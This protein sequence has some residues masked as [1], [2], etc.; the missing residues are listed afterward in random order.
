M[1]TTSGELT[2]SPLGDDVGFNWV[3][4]V[5][6]LFFLFYFNRL[7]AT[8][9]SYG[10][11]AWTWHKY[12][13]YID[14][15]A[16]Q[17]SLLG[18]R[19]FFKGLRYH[20]NNETILIH[21]GFITWCYWLR[22][23]R[24]LHVDKAKVSGPKRM[25]SDSENEGNKYHSSTVGVEDV[26]IQNPYKLPCRINISLH[27][28]EWFVY[29]RSAA[30][31]AVIASMTE[32]KEPVDASSDQQYKFEVFESGLRKRTKVTD[33]EKVDPISKSSNSSEND[34]SPLTESLGLGLSKGDPKSHESSST[35]QTRLNKVRSDDHTSPGGA[36]IL[37]FLPIQVTCIKA[38][39]VL[40][41]ENTKSVL[42]AKAD[43][44][45]GEIDA[46]SSKTLDQYRQ[47]INFEFDHPVVQ[48]KPNDDYKEDQTATATRIKRGETDHPDPEKTH[49]HNHTFL[50]RQ[51][52]KVWHALQD[53]VPA[54]RS[55]VDS[56]S[57]SD[58]PPNNSPQTG[59]GFTGWQGL[60]RYLDEN[61]QD[62]KARWSAIEYATV[63]TIADSPK[64]T[65][66]F[67][68]D[69]VGT[70][71][72]K[73]GHQ[74]MGN[75]GRIR[76]INGD[77][78]PEWG[79]D[80]LLNGA[81]I[82]YGPWADRQRADI[83]RAFFPS[84]CKDT[85]P[86][87]NLVPGQFRVPT[88]FKV[89][90]EFDKE[91]TVRIPIRE[92]SKNWRWAKH[93]D[94]IGARQDNQKGRSSKHRRR[95]ADKGNPGPEIRPFGW[96][97]VKVGANATASY[98]M[99]MVAGPSG[100]SNTLELDL[101]NTEI[102]TSVNHG[103]LWRSVDNKISCDLSNP[104]KW[105][106]H[107]TWEFDVASNGLELFLLREHIF[108]L[109]DLV[110]D[111]ASGPPPDYLTYSPFRY[112]VNLHLDNFRLYLNVNDSN[113]INNPS[114]FDDNTFIII[115][116]SVLN[117]K[118]CI[119]LDTYRPFRN[120][121]SFDVDG[122]HGGLN[123]H[124][125]PWNTQATFLRS[126]ELA[127]LKTLAINGKY[128]F[129]ADT[130][131]SNTDTLLL[132]L[133]G[134]AP[135]A[136]FYG[137]VI[138]Y[139]LK[140]KDNYFGDDIRFKTLEE[141]QQVLRAQ[142]EDDNEARDVQP[143]KKSNDLDVI[144][145]ITVDDSSVILPSNLY[146]AKEHIRIEIATIA[147]D[148]RFTNY[149]M[150]LDVI[151]S[152]LA[153][154]L[155][156][157][158]SGSTTPLSATSST[159][160]FIDGVNASGNRLFGLPPTEPTY[161]CNWDFGV[162]AVTGEC[163]MDF[164]GRLAGG[165]RAFAFSFE[166]DENALPSISEVIL[167]DI[168]FLR[169]SLQSIRIWLH[170][171][172][173][174]FLFSTANISVSFND[175][176]GSHYSQK[177]NI[178][179]P[180]VHLGCVDAESAS[181]HRSRTQ[182]PVETHAFVQTALSIAMVQ[183]KLGFEKDRQLQQ[184]H[185]KRHDQRTH[186][187][188]FLLHPNLL[189]DSM[190]VGV[191]PPAMCI[192]PIALP[193]SSDVDAPPACQ[194]IHSEKS[195]LYQDRFTGRKS[196]FL[197]ISSTSQ[198]SDISILRPNSSRKRGDSRP[199]DSRSR[200]LQAGA[201]PGR[202][203]P[204]RDISAS[205]GRRSSFYSAVGDHR[206][207]PPSTVTFSS[208][209]MAPYFPLEGVEPDKKDLPPTWEDSEECHSFKEARF[210]LDDVQPDRVN[211]NAAHVSFM[212]ELPSGLC[213]VF[214][215]KAVSA[216]AG[217]VAALQASDP[218]DILDEL[219]IDSMSDIFDLKKHR[220]MTRKVTDLSVRAPSIRL[221]FLNAFT[222]DRS[223]TSAEMHDQYDMSIS[224]LAVTTRS[225][226][227]ATSENNLASQIQATSSTFHLSLASIDVSAKERYTDIQDPQVAINGVLE[228]V[229]CWVVSGEAT[230]AT[231]AF[232]GIEVA[233]ASSKIEYLAS[234]LH[235]TGLL[236]SD[237]SGTFSNLTAQQ[238]N[239]LQ[240]FTYL[241]A[242]AGQQATDPLFLTRPSYVLRSAT[243]HLRTTDSWKIITRLRHMYDSLHD[244]TKQDISMRCSNNSET[245]PENA[246]EN[247]LSGFDNWRSWDLND[248]NTCLV[249]KRVYGP[250]LENNMPKTETSWP[251]KMTFRTELV[252]LV[253]DPG[254]K[255]NEI[256]LAEIVAT[257]E[258]KTVNVKA[259]SQSP[260]DADISEMTVVQLFCAD[261][262]INLNWELCELAD[263]IMKLYNQGNGESSNDNRRNQSPVRSGQSTPMR[264]KHD[265]HI[266]VATD[267]GSITLDTINIRATSLSKGLNASFVVTDIRTGEKRKAATLMLAAEAA[268][269]KITSHSQELT[270][271]QIHFPS[272]FISH[273][274]QLDNGIPINTIKVA[275][276]C[277]K[278]SFAVRQDI[279]ALVEVLDLIIGD[280]AAQ[281]Y[282]LKKNM[283]AI[284]SQTRFV[285]V[286]RKP[287]SVTKINVALVL[288]KYDISILL[289]QSL[290]YNISGI[291]ARASLAAEMGSEVV[292]DFDVKENSHDMQTIFANSSRSISLLQVPPTNG[293]ITCHILENET[294]VSVFASVEPVELDAA[295][296]HSLLTA[297]N[298]PE[299]SSVIADVKE[300]V[301]IMETHLEEIFGTSQKPTSKE[302]KMFI[303]DA[304]L[305][306]A[307]FNIFANAHGHRGDSNRAR[308]DFNLGCVQL[309]LANRLDQDGPVLAFPEMRVSLQEIMFELSRWNK[310]GMEPCGN[311]AFAAF[312]T[313]TS[314]LSDT[315]NE[316]R[317]FHLKSNALKINLF[318]DTASSVLDVIGYLQEKIKDLDL[319]REKDYLRRLRQSKPRIAI[320]EDDQDAGASIT[321]STIMFSSMY[322]LE[323]LNVQV[324]WLVG[325]YTRE[326]S[327]QQ[328]REDLV[329]SLKRIDLSTKKENSARLTIE[330]L[331]L[332]MVPASQDKTQRTLNSALL[333]EVIFNVGYVSTQDTRRLAFQ[334][335]GKSLDLR[336]TSQFII[337]ASALR[338]S[339]ESAAEKVRAV[340]A[341]W[342][343]PAPGPPTEANRRQ[344][345]F[346][347]K[348][349]ESLLIDADFAG[350][351]VYLS[352]K[353]TPESTHAVSATTSGRTPQ[354]GRYGQF[355]QTD[356]S[357]NT[358]LRAPGLAWRVEFKDNGLDEPS[359][360]AELKVD[361]S[362]NI[363]Y[364]TVVPLIMEISSTVKEIVS[365]DDTDKKP[366]E[367]KVSPQKF[368]SADED[369]I[370]TADPSAVLG[371]TRLN[372]GL[373]ICR[374]EFSLSC[375]PI[376]R[377]AATARFDDIYLTVNTVR[378][379]EHGHFFAA[380]AT[381]S[382]LQASVQH[383]YSREST[384]SFDVDSVFL[385]LM[386]SK[387]VSG[388]SGLSAI[389]K[390][391]PMKVLVN[392]KQLQDF[393]LFRE[394]WVP[395]EIRQSSSTPA[396]VPSTLQ[397]QT[398]LVQRYQQVAATGAF[399][400][401]ATISIAEL[402]VQLDLGQA[403]GKSAFMISN[404]W[405]SSK[406][407]SDWEQNL[408]L[409]F[410]K[411]GVDST[412]RMSG[413]VALQ[414]FKIRTSIQWPAR[415]KALNQTP[416]VQGSL[417]FS[418]FRVKAAFDYHA[419]LV[420]DIT[421]FKFYMY[422][423]RSGAHA[424][425]DRLVA[426]LDGEAVQVFCTT[427]TAAQAIALYQA[428]LRLA[429]EKR[430]NYE[431]SLSEIEKF[432]QR[433]SISHPTSP[434][435]PKHEL[436]KHD[437]D[438]IAKS[439]ISLH[440]DVIVTLNAVNMGVFPNTFS[441]HQVFKLEAL[442]AQARF[443]VT[444]DNGKI[445][446][447]LG[448]TLGQLRIGLA[449]VKNIDMPKPL[450]VE[451][452]VNSATGSRGGTILKVPKVEA[453]MQTWQVPNSNHIDYIF[454]SSFEG[455]VE[456]GWNYSRISYIRSMWA[457][458]SK[459]LAQKLGKP[460]PISAVKI[461][462]VPDEED[463]ERKEGE[464]QKITAE[465]NVP[466]S[467]YDYTALEPPIIETPQ[468]RD[469]GEATPPLEWIG[470][471]RDRMPNL[472][473]QIVI[474]TLLELAS[475]VEDAYAKILG[476]S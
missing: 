15:Q 49:V 253:L 144:L 316:V 38:A 151:L 359:L 370:L 143:H 154:S 76:N 405:I 394:I 187:A 134:N 70:V 350:A 282:G 299:I 175:W 447:I 161:V 255:Q 19:I 96:L 266:L 409:G 164:F 471:H 64:A 411:V 416:L 460:L 53:L 77:P 281:L 165:A 254:P 355:T 92:E 113:I 279:L 260:R 116:G 336:L 129:C 378:S 186:R 152:T 380:S 18:G 437:E 188:D 392:A 217:L 432:M 286:E 105:N 439:P 173:A 454:K 21:S 339:I 3:F 149:Y 265:L 234:L 8:L 28:A 123:L 267:K 33:P 461:T 387:H 242:A 383:V 229:A 57:S 468:L 226:N 272:I 305:T 252:R 232:K 382:R 288:D 181:R 278:L 50:H 385:S 111:W 29:N 313:A 7:F 27:G 257:F 56:I 444:M 34:D 428:F 302:A 334:A 390:I 319:S 430:S 381:F 44:A 170:V 400:W 11:R 107:R 128:Q 43:R 442:N 249:I 31:D 451:D 66:S 109:I 67:Y 71:P 59:P 360:N 91:T 277:Q 357:S 376:A 462:G 474:V 136:Q 330:D 68:W 63:S 369:N 108:L 333:P 424:K 168:T 14:I 155:G 119:P 340:S 211:E 250:S 258:N 285:E 58:H 180:E 445:H 102:T 248:T 60:S 270:T 23:V 80:L 36:F 47:L 135:S 25:S 121:I 61:E 446:S 133:H 218:A 332:Q 342:S 475:E 241:V 115:F 189:D 199:M 341:T 311:L 441:D 41:N 283:P 287:K 178:L 112:M 280:E 1:S 236:A 402:D 114:D 51:R 298:R 62:E 73:P 13:V 328:E 207:L 275:G 148:I 176:A 89:Y 166:D 206:V 74:E 90:I 307:G 466:Q 303:Y 6:T 156:S 386:N 231:V 130:S 322:S 465:V 12:R 10:L 87:K 349:M 230:S 346:G 320:N 247:V 227:A 352:G 321:G 318:A 427:A 162:G 354:P 9:V 293:R 431:A 399:P 401:N 291:V 215:P 429:Q 463:G 110:D 55:S 410:D 356:A 37:R 182:H 45:T 368:M 54:F 219:Q 30:Y 304:H 294:V 223:G 407:N 284:P 98:S 72:E 193:V 192:P 396:P 140:I 137:F 300:D 169:A 440:T 124:I 16:L 393:L 464:Q 414:D 138:R 373:R 375:Q 326:N 179:V 81:I 310:N 433:K 225:E 273:E 469:M 139:F 82:N 398:Y 366:L 205:T 118:V 126:T 79:L 289:L 224:R 361:A 331:Q 353:K 216:V 365:D 191:D 103:L 48:M 46:T 174:A 122:M 40:G 418:Q 196:S 75:E 312:L 190:L 391:S 452:V 436:H 374:Q 203:T 160:L 78:P 251:V 457:S 426:I 308:L 32:D 145:A 384:G 141:Y 314:K 455:K 417:G 423:V 317:S 324:C 99:D 421:S 262:S 172:E 147:A 443:A 183:R 35:S 327:S 408:C 239:R 212:I 458:H 97:D 435:P 210:A 65:M 86:S 467:K 269:S 2:A 93:A 364:P 117:A 397:S 290:T 450:S 100:F 213:G 163:T 184:E 347:T 233:T 88:E 214:N 228:D 158:Q 150:D 438:K 264:L 337:P 271:Y 84:L 127:T 146:S 403:I 39:V 295:A 95:K 261:I 358:V 85:T 434:T 315:G 338:K 406:K 419:F 301:K 476:S 449:G 208:S 404:F 422:N 222:P 377:V 22:N 240:L 171:E 292:F 69:V 325:T 335:A 235:R 24:G 448:L 159:Q 17:I 131:S 306:L 5:E 344:P 296:V 209:Y 197:S 453:T 200:S 297:L 177:L 244:S 167:H 412:G 459:A 343:T 198:R 125:P 185:V 246:R 389:L 237:M 388:T 220:N 195:S 106:G 470:L 142:R 256:S 473:H 395:P 367:P 243:D 221:R 157:E 371:R 351:V 132:T 309:V 259:E 456:V 238:R 472:T 26:G 323:L 83:Q 201:G 202:R 372:L 204:L 274:E 245:V 276:N 348:R 94:S 268:T 425:G 101:P 413:F 20:G 379:T 263:D 362:S 120:A 52:R 329:L 42:I 415:E 420:A 104:L 194:S 363:L 4:L 345:F 153:F